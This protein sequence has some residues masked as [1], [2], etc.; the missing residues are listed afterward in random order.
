MIIG[1]YPSI[2]VKRTAPTTHTMHITKRQ[3]NRPPCLPGEEYTRI[4]GEIEDLRSRRSIVTEAEIVRR[5]TLVKVQE[6]NKVLR[7][8]D[9][10]QEFDEKLFGMLVER[11]KVINMVQVELRLRAGVVEII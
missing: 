9:G 11:V 10:V 1:F 6:I 7:G 2:C 5:E 8:M 4:N 3:E